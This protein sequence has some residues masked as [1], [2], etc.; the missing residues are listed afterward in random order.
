[1][2]NFGFDNKCDEVYGMKVI[3]IEDFFLL[4]KVFFGAVFFSFAFLL[5]LKD[6]RTYRFIIKI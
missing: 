4:H 5:Q 6:H 2:E 3:F 1:M